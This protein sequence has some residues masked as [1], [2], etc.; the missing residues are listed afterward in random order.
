MFSYTPYIGWVI[1]IVVLASA[2]FRHNESVRF[3]AFQGLY[4]FVACLIM[5]WVLSPMI[6]FSDG[7]PMDDFFRHMPE[8]AVIG[9]GVFMMV[10]LSQGQS[11]RL[12]LIGELAERSVSEQR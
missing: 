5:R 8:L 10:K 2:R 6:R 7:F 3:H 4:L 12:P 1:A 9:L 11:Y